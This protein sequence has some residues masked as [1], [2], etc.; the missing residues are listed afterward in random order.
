MTQ[1]TQNAREIAGLDVRLTRHI[2][3]AEQKHD[4]LDEVLVRIELH[5]ARIEGVLGFLKWG[6]PVALTLVGMIIAGVLAYK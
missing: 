3:W 1:E 4:H 5:L 2:E 6:I